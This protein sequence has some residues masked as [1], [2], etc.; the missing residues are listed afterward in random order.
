MSIFQYQG[1][2]ANTVTGISSDLMLIA[3]I[4]GEKEIHEG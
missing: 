4:L 2:N 1:S 3:D